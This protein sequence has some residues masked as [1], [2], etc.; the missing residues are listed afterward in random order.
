M[1]A[2]QDAAAV[3]FASPYDAIAHGPRAA[4]S[5]RG[6][7]ASVP[8]H[9][10]AAISIPAGL[11]AQDFVAAARASATSDGPAILFQPLW[12]PALKESGQRVLLP[13]IIRSPAPAPG[14]TGAAASMAQTVSD[15]A[16]AAFGARGGKIKVRLGAPVSA[17]AVNAA[18]QGWDGVDIPAGDAQVAAKPIVMMAV[19]DDATP[20]A[21]VDLRDKAGRTRVECCHLQ[22][23][24]AASGGTTPYGLEFSRA[25]IDALLARH[26]PDEDAIYAASGALAFSRPDTPA[27]SRLAS[28]GAHVLGAAAGFRHGRRWTAYETPQFDLDQLRVIAV[29]LPVQP[30]LDAALYGRDGAILA[31]AHYIFNQADKIAAAYGQSG[32]PLIINISYGFTAGPHNGQTDIE[33]ELARL[34]ALRRAA[35]IKAPTHV[36]LPAGN[37]FAASLVATLSATDFKP[38][39]DSARADLGW[40]V[41]PDDRTRNVLE[42]WFAPDADLSSLSLDLIAP[43]GGGV[44]FAPGDLAGDFVDREILARGGRVGVCACQSTGGM[45]YLSIVLNP[46]EWT[47]GAAA[48]DLAPAGRWDLR[49]TCADPAALKGP[50]KCRIQRDHDRPGAYRGARQSYFDDPAD[51]P[52]AYHGGPSTRDAGKVRRY[53][54]INGMATNE[55]FIVVGGYDARRG[56]PS[57]YSS[58]GE[59]PAGAPAPRGGQV[60]CSAPTDT[61]SALRGR[62]GAGARSGAHFRLVGTSSAAPQVARALA[63]AY[64]QNPCGW[65]HVG[66][67][68]DGVP[69]SALGAVET[70]P[71]AETPSMDETDGPGRAARLG[72]AIFS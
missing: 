7:A 21:H 20:F 11:S 56:E 24:F 15:V 13:A 1:A 41:S 2:D 63:R 39:G 12:A 37:T 16:A 35:P 31:G 54:S 30:E 49:L 29:Q 57:R 17:S 53:G 8:A 6:R 67:T 3:E 44:S 55:A 45:R 48:L 26:G 47:P 69:L 22:P 5:T 70:P 18:A 4:R 27:L 36:V 60:T 68:I 42:I 64:L 58:A 59:L 34:V 19:I 61:S 14:A 71:S 25:D 66:K 40:R 23:V 51:A 28:H 43:R 62:V 72:G 46:T 38:E 52:V 33:I 10:G 50:V 9:V 65:S 32:A